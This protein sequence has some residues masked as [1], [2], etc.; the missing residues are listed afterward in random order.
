MPKSQ[1]ILLTEAEIFPVNE[2]IRAE[3]ERNGFELVEM[4]GGAHDDI[5]EA[6]RDCM[7]VLLFHAYVPESLLT[8][9]PSVRILARVGTGYER[10]DV[11][12]AKAR[13]VAV[14][15]LPGV[16][17]EELADHATMLL[18]M[19]A[20][21]MPFFL[22]ERMKRNWPKVVAFPDT[23]PLSEQTLGV[24]GLGPS[25]RAMVPRAK[26]LGLSV[27]AWSRTLRPGLG[28]QL[29]YEEASLA[30]VLAC[31]YVSLHVALTPETERLISHDTLKHFKPSA[32]LLNISRGGLVDQDALLEA[33]D[34]G[35]L[36]GA[37]LDVVSPEPLPDNHPIWTHPKVI[38]T[39]HSGSYTATGYNRSLKTAIEDIFAFARG[40]QPKHLVPEFSM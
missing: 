18:L 34:A 27:R 8:R 37:G 16:F 14:T 33:L 24:V 1:R 17:T 35:R 29:G 26:A 25:G 22:D 3:I 10:I 13:G 38:L 5:V 20:R 9:L 28:A 6:G 36:R 39:F 2:D 7:A 30:E 23:F 11:E 4:V 40:E 32:V 19:F 15:F 12:A 21:Q 31:D